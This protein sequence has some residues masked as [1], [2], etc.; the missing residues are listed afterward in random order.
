MTYAATVRE[1]LETRRRQ[2]MAFERAW[3]EALAEHPT[4]DDWKHANGGE[5]PLRFLYR[6]FQ[7]AYYN[8]R[9]ERGRCRVE[10]SGTPN[11][12]AVPSPGIGDGPRAPRCRSR[13]DCDRLATRGRFG[14]WWCD[15]HGDELERI[16]GKLAETQAVGSTPAEAVQRGRERGAWR[17]KDAA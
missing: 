13:D 11:R 1:E 6:H 12:E 8:D 17:R 14:P 16:A 9:S 10:G 15:H 2:G 7:A 4:P 3:P 5:S